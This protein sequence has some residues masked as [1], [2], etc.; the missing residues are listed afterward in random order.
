MTMSVYTVTSKSMTLHWTR[1]SGA[2]FYQLTA[3]PK[4]SLQGQVFVQFGQ[5]TIMG[6]ITSLTPD[7]QYKVK[8]E[9]MNTQMT[10]LAS[11]ETD[12]MTGQ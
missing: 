2:N 7:T 3:T 9:A 4:N 11:A 1:I 5:N 6:S 10:V 12:A 8:V